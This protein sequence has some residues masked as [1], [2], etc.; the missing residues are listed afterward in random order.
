[1]K[2][3]SLDKAEKMPEAIAEKSFDI[4]GLPERQRLFIKHYLVTKNAS[5]AC[6]LSG[7]SKR[8][9]ADTGHRLLNDPKIRRYIDEKSDW[10]FEEWCEKVKGVYL[11]HGDNWQASLKSLE[12]YGKGKGFCRDSTVNI[13]QLSVSQDDILRLRKS[14]AGKGLQLEHTANSIESKEVVLDIGGVVE[15]VGEPPATPLDMHTTT[16]QNAQ[17]NKEPD[18]K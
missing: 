4:Q 12:L 9:A 2:E 13:N 7:Y 16:P 1:M 17:Q 15:R 5:E 8:N 6:R 11:Q 10:T 14:L 3:K 18:G